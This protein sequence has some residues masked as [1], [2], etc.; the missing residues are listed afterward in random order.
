MN[1]VLS[2]NYS[3]DFNLFVENIEGQSCDI[4]T[5][6]EVPSVLSAFQ[7]ISSQWFRVE[8]EITAINLRINENFIEN[9]LGNP[10]IYDFH[11]NR[12]A[13][14]TFQSVINENNNSAIFWK[15][16]GHEK[17][18]SLKI[19]NDPKGAVTDYIQR[20]LVIEIKDGRS[21]ILKTISNQYDIDYRQIGNDKGLNL[22]MLAAN[23]NR[24]DI[25]EQ[26]LLY[27]LDI[28]FENRDGLNAIEC[29][30]SNYINNLEDPDI[31]VKSN[32]IILI[33]LNANSKFPRD[34]DFKKA[35]EEFQSFLQMCENLHSLAAKD[36]FEEIK[37]VLDQK[38]NLCHFYDRDNK[39]LLAYSLLEGKQEIVEFLSNGISIGCHEDLDE[40]YED[41]PGRALRNK[42]QIYA[43]ELPESHLFILRSK[44][45]IG[46]NDR[47]SH[48]RWKYIEEAFRIIDSNEKCSKILKVASTFKKLRI[49]FDFIQDTVY[50]LDPTQS[51]F[52]GGVAYNTGLIYIGAKYLIDP[53]RKFEVFGV[54]IHELCH[55]ALNIT[56]MNNFNPYSMGESVEKMLFENLVVNECKKYKRYEI[57]VSNVFDSYPLEYQHSELIVTVVQMLMHYFVK[58]PAVRCH[59]SFKIFRNKQNY[60]KLFKFFEKYVEIDLEKALI[61]LKLL[62][63][64]DYDIQFKELTEPMKSKILHSNIIFQG[65]KASFYDIIGD[66][67]EI[68]KLLNSQQ[69]RTILV[70]DDPIVIGSPCTVSVNK[71]FIERKF[72]IQKLVD[73]GMDI[74]LSDSN[75][76]KPYE[77]FNI[78]SALRKIMNEEPSELKR[79]TWYVPLN[80]KPEDF[81]KIKDFEMIKE[82]TRESKIFVLADY[83]GAGKTTTFKSLTEKLKESYKNYWVSFINLRKHIDVFEVY[84]KN[85][86]SIKSIPRLL[87]DVVTESSDM[88]K[89]IFYKLLNENKVIL[90][91]DGVD[92]ISPRYNQF[93][94]NVLKILRYNTKNQLW[95]STRPQHALQMAEMLGILIHN[96]IPFTE[97]ERR[98]SV[99]ETLKSFNITKD[100]LL[101]KAIDDFEK[102]F[103]TIEVRSNGQFYINNPLL[104]GIFSEL[105]SEG[106]I[107]MISTSFGGIYEKMIDKQKRKVDKR[108]AINDRDPFEEFSLK[109]VHQVFAIKLLITEDSEQRYGI[110]LDDFVILKE[111]KKRKLN[112]TS[113]KIQRYGFL[114]VDIRDDNSS[115]D[116]IHRTYAEFFVAD[117]IISFVYRSDEGTKD[118]EFEKIFKVM[119]LI[120]GEFNE[121]IIVRNFIFSYIKNELYVNPC[122]VHKKISELIIAK[123]PKNHKFSYEFKSIQSLEYWSTFFIYEP[124]TLKKLW[125]LNEKEDLFKKT[126][127][128]FKNSWTNDSDLIKNILNYKT[129]KNYSIP[130]E[131]IN[132]DK[133]VSLLEDIFA[134]V[135]NIFGVCWHMILD[136]CRHSLVSNEE[137]DSYKSDK[138]Y[139]NFNK[140]LLKLLSLMEKNYSNKERQIIHESYFNMVLVKKSISRHVY[141]AIIHNILHYIQYDITINLISFT[142]TSQIRAKVLKFLIE[143]LNGG[144]YWQSEIE[145]GFLKYLGQKI[146]V[147]L[148]K[149][150]DDIRKLLFRNYRTDT[151]LLVRAIQSNSTEVFRLYKNL[152]H[153]YSNSWD[154]IH[155]QKIFGNHFRLSSNFVHLTE[156]ILKEFEEL[157]IEIFKSNVLLQSIALDDLKTFKKFKHF[158][159]QST[160]ILNKSNLLDAFL[161]HFHPE[162]G[163]FD[164]Q[165]ETIQELKSF[166]EDIFYSDKEKFSEYKRNCKFISMMFGDAVWIKRRESLDIESN[167]AVHSE[168]TLERLF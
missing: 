76:S 27:G 125:L 16:F 104:V 33:L 65:E 133:A 10:S 3:E 149:N 109:K 93:L 45:K 150:G 26:I 86:T 59:N 11:K 87:F 115:I 90:L 1:K 69:I 155:F 94:V 34:F 167:N 21:G 144:I 78:E 151:H 30:W 130:S 37:T 137:L 147:L 6:N 123:F 108:V 99:V 132:I 43:K 73:F 120:D 68:L 71:K 134:V 25:I 131:M 156:P 41:V 146:E 121:F 129:F 107:D 62:D 82:E 38:P 110:K 4:L 81:D 157:F 162:I 39:S 28:D 35:S 142:L 36:K 60:N 40:I 17:F 31:S 153:K 139:D 42:Y 32:K 52:T 168:F 12:V 80:I 15:T 138:T 91:V 105:Y 55:V 124:E 64:H 166:I 95:I 48:E 77:P 112:F 145:F 57:I 165:T 92:E 22:L 63:D 20:F 136:Q 97:L 140:N 53:E 102:F 18:Y 74:S 158:Y 56:Y 75:S 9:F 116:F 96:F 113:E 98:Q 135:E 50:Y 89:R 66:E 72:V 103:K 154:G 141:L 119:E 84:Q 161:E 58:N 24:D 8:T 117:F 14:I 51:K 152:F 128:H 143:L 126:L 148:N 13:L 122:P 164:T 83:A 54:I 159:Q 101:S 106:E 100:D 23:D 44:C 85:G 163:N 114:T 160:N 111:W 88:E 5:I 67:H 70:Y 127:F 2:T 29:A 118:E 46:Y 47:N 7:I 79:S 19:S 49:Y 61:V